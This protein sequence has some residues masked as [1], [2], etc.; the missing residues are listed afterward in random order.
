MSELDIRLVRCFVTVAKERSFTRA[1]E[2]LGMA[3][4]W[5]SVQI[6]KLEEQLG[7]QLFD[8]NRNRIVTVSPEAEAFLPVAQ[9]CLIAADRAVVAARRIREHAAVSLKLGAPDFSA[10]IPTRVA[11]I[12]AF[13]ARHPK[14]EIEIVNA[15]T[16]ELLKRLD[17]GEIDMAFTLG[18]HVDPQTEALVLARY[19]LGVLAETKRLRTD[20]PLSLS[21]FAGKPLALFRRNINPA[22]Y[23]SIAPVLEAAGIVVTDLPE[24]ALPS[25]PRFVQRTGTCAVAAEWEA[26]TAHLPGDF[27]VVPFDEPALVF[28]FNLVRRIDDRRPAVAALWTFA[29]NSI[30]AVA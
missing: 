4:P 15:W 11:I 13:L 29:L 2:R 5:L 10:E 9:E 14:I 22:L 18:P 16:L 8:R 7:F 20:R 25:V 23:D 26:G 19:R 12:D 24:P 21:A 17:Y 3:Q 28:N 27:S 30:S 1:A 6:R